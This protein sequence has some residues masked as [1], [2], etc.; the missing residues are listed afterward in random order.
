MRIE[1]PVFFDPH[2]H[3]REG[4][5]MFGAIAQ[6]S[7]FCGRVCAMLNLEKPLDEAGIR[8]YLWETG[9][10]LAS[11]ER[12]M[13]V[14][15]V[16]MLGDETTPEQIAAWATCG[17]VSAK[18]M[19]SGATTNSHHGVTNPESLA[20][21][22]VLEKMSDLG[23]VLQVHCEMPPGPDGSTID[24]ALGAEQEFIET[25][26][27]LAASYPRLKMV[28]EHISTREA[29]KAIEPFANVAATITPHHLTMTTDDVL[30]LTYKWI[31][32]PH[33]WCRPIAKSE[34]DRQALIETACSN[35]PRIFFGSDYAPHSAQDKRRTPPPAGCASYPAGPYVL[36]RL[37]IER[38]LGAQWLANFTSRR[39]MDFF[40]ISSNQ[41][42]TLIL[43]DR[44]TLTVMGSRASGAVEDDDV[45]PWLKGEAFDFAWRRFSLQ[46]IG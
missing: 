35:N 40:G 18:Y 1:T 6:T 44:E 33:N 19:P 31:A 15:P 8:G 32:N 24:W 5:K 37:A 38:D 30:D 28:F 14:M 12:K 7:L 21:S 11:L 16:P 25:F 22:G 20:E 2:V 34:E 39:A 43:S 4:I 27:N 45:E 46:T 26:C 17:A 36:A 42:E 13:T 3:L 41:Q 9:R 10:H 29:L 23:L